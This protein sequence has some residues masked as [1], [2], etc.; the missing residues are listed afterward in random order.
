[1]G[2][3]GQVKLG[4]RN[5]L[6]AIDD[7][8]ERR[9]RYEQLVARAYERGK[10]LNEASNFGIDETIDPADSRRWIMAVLKSHRWDPKPPGKK[11][12]CVDGGKRL[13]AR[14]SAIGPACITLSRHGNDG[15]SIVSRGRC[16]PPTRRRLKA[17]RDIDLQ[18]ASAYHTVQTP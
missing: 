10:A 13:T 8:D 14:L 3:E 2:L 7:P 6:S 9:Q 1:M 16:A 12:P 5:E 11:R 17:F 15:G 4:F 18:S